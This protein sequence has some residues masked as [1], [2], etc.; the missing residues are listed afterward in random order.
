MGGKQIQDNILIVQEVLHQLRVRKRKWKFQAM[1]KLDTKKAYNKVEWDFLD[2][3]LQ[4]LSFCDKWVDRVMKCVKTISFN[5]CGKP[6]HLFW[7]P[8]T[9][10]VDFLA[11]P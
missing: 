2:A 10:W 5:V 8:A 7:R 3:C 4:R 11:P 9:Y 1:L 6:L